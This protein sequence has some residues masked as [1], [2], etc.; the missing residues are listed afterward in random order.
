MVSESSETDFMPSIYSIEDSKIRLGPMIDDIAEVASFEGMYAGIA[1][2][3][4]GIEAYGK[5]EKVT[6][7]RNGNEYHRVLIGSRQMGGRDYIKLL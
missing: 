5:L 2:E 1:E 7:V 6:D 4:E 3:G